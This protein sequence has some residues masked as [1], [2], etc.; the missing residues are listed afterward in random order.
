MAVRTR[1]GHPSHLK[2]LSHNC[3]DPFPKERDIYRL[4]GLQHGEIFGGHFS[5][6]HR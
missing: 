4:Q 5:A 2:I 1:L 3:N 6:N